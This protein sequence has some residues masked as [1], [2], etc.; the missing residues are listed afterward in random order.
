MDMGQWSLQRRERF[1]IL[2]IDLWTTR[3]KC[4]NWQQTDD[5]IGIDQR[6]LRAKRL[7]ADWSK[8]AAA[9]TKGRSILST[10]INGRV[11]NVLASFSRPTNQFLPNN[12]RTAAE[13]V[14]LILSASP[15]L[16]NILYDQCI[17][18]NYRWETR[19]RLQPNQISELQWACLPIPVHHA[20]VVPLF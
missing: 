17:W 6:Q 14:R 5:G 15:L 18:H 8:S 12:Q 9:T 7:I 16:P 11:A 3:V 4:R 13:D 10:I 2:F 20:I 1:V 19:R